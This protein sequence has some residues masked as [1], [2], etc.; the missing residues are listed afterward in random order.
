MSS[1]PA[2][3]TLSVRVPRL[4]TSAVGWS[5]PGVQQA[6]DEREKAYKVACYQRPKSGRLMTFGLW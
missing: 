2:E 6:T 3:E 4:A 1:G 5:G